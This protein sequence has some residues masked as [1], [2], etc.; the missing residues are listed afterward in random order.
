[1]NDSLV[2][3]LA[4]AAAAAFVGAVYQVVSDLFLRDRARVSDRVDVEFLKR[5]A[6]GAAAKAKKASLFKNLDQVAGARAEARSPTWMERFERNWPF[7]HSMARSAASKESYETKPNP[8]ERPVS[9]SRITLGW[10]V[11]PPKALKVS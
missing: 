5:K 1:M 3:G 2:M 4:A 7:M 11:R 6:A 10:S 9:G 8:L